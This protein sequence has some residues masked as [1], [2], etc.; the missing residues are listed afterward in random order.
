MWFVWALAQFLSTLSPLPYPTASMLFSLASLVAKGSHAT[1]AKFLPKSSKSWTSHWLDQPRSHVLGHMIKI[2]PIK[3]WSG[4]SH[5][6]PRAAT[7]GKD[8][9]GNSHW[10]GLQHTYYFI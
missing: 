1:V 6:N 8:A 2:K 4:Q 9:R 5:S 10:Q 7:F 3:H